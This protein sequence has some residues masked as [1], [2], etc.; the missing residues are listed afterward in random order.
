M[1]PDSDF[2]GGLLNMEGL[3][4]P[5]S[6]LMLLYFNNPTLCPFKE[7]LNARLNGGVSLSSLI[8]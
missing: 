8:G 6:A 3:L 4:K 2:V 1:C 5:K 7:K